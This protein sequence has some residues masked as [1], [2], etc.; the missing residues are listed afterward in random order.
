LR[1]LPA[2]EDAVK[3]EQLWECR[4]SGGRRL[5]LRTRQYLFCIGK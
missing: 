1:L 2:G 3:L 5:Y 4:L